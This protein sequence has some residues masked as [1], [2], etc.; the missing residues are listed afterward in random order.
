MSATRTALMRNPTVRK[1][2]N[3]LYDRT[4]PMASFFVWLAG[5]S[6]IYYGFLMPQEQ[7]HINR[8]NKTVKVVKTNPG[9]RTTL[10]FGSLVAAWIGWKI[11]KQGCKSAGPVWAIGYFVVALIVMFLINVLL[12]SWREHV[13]PTESSQVLRL[14]DTN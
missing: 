5:F 13:R 4:C 11:I 7:V 2:V 14:L 12:L 9:L 10:V 6:A 3:F 8:D 1:G